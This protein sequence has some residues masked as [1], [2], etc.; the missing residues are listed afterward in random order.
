MYLC[1]YR[2]PATNSELGLQLQ[3]LSED[4]YQLLIKH[5]INRN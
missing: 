3:Q 4:K 2:R 5:T 1:P